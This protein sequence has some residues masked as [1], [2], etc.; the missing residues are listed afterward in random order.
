M[1]ERKH[2]HRD[3]M[4]SSKKADIMSGVSVMICFLLT[5]TSLCFSQ[6]S[7]FIWIAAIFGMAGWI[8]W[9]VGKL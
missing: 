5:F 4:E 2:D 1:K 3:K 7:W 8:C 6:L 9:E